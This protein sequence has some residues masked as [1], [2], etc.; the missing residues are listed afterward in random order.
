MGSR[1]YNRPSNV[2]ALLFILIALENAITG[3]INLQI[4]DVAAG[5]AKC[6]SLDV[7]LATTA[8]GAANS[9]W[10][11]DLL[12]ALVA[13]VLAALLLLRPERLVYAA[14]AGWSA[15]AFF[16]NLV[17]RH[18][19]K[20][21][22]YLFTFRAGFYLVAFAIAA[23]LAVIEWK[24]YM[25]HQAA[26]KAAAAADRAAADKAA[27]RASKPAAPAIRRRNP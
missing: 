2:I 26:E 19:D 18:S 10:Y 7:I 4:P 9:G 17:A 8:C 24:S 16:A 21:I 12:T 22:D 23:V 3:L 14:A 25:D 5:G 6:P 13:G 27:A 11:A 15:I 20:S 1:S